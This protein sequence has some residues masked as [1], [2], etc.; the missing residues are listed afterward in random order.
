MELNAPNKTGGE[1]K[2]NVEEEECAG[3]PER[4]IYYDKDRDKRHRDAWPKCHAAGGSSG[5][6]VTGWF[7]AG[8]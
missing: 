4:K 3:W 8:N 1:D 6:A 5:W 2:E 7:E